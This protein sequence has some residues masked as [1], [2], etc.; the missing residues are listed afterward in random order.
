ML[1]GWI[2][3]YIVCGLIFGRIVRQFDLPPEL[4]FAVFSCWPLFVVIGLACGVA[5]GIVWIIEKLP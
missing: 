3:G 4:L 5:Y 1:A 2:V